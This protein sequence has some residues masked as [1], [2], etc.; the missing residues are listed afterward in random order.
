MDALGALLE[1]EDIA[2]YLQSPAVAEGPKKAMIATLG[3]DAGFNEYT[4]NFLNL[5]VDR[6]RMDIVSDVIEA[7]ETKY[8]E[9]TDTQVHLC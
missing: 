1:S 7:F 5:L 9:I 6:Q 2:E 8:C 3:S 4:L